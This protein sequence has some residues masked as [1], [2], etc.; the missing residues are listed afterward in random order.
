MDYFKPFL[1]VAGIMLLLAVPPMWPYAYYEFMRV[2]VCVAA[3]FGAYTALQAGQTG[4]LWALGAMAA[5]FNPIAPIHLDKEAWT[6]PDIVG[7]LIMFVAAVR[8]KHPGK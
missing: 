8:L 1:I 3:I 6:I 7:A 5:L 2:V 4:W